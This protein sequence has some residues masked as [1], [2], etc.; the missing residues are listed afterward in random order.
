MKLESI[1]T[2]LAS[3]AAFAATT[4]HATQTAERSCLSQPEL[5]ALI[6]SIMPD[7]V[8]GLVGV[9]RPVLPAGAYLQK[10]G[11]AL[12]AAFDAEARGSSDAAG[13][14]IMKVAGVKGEVSADL[15][16]EALAKVKQEIGVEL[17]KEIKA[18]DCPAIDRLLF[19]MSPLSPAN[20]AGLIGTIGTIVEADKADKPGKGAT[21]KKSGFPPICPIIFD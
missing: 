14:A 11:D 1:M 17:A 13:A 12:I 4:A 5:Q 3:M 6:A 16:A 15:S 10:N 20:L 7:A 19:H 2:A 9:C 18:K 21:R 8:R